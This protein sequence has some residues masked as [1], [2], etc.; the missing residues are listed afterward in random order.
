MKGFHQVPVRLCD[1]PKTAFV[2]PWGKYQYRYMPFGLRNAPSTFQRLMDRVLHNVISFSK[3][4]IDDIVVYSSFWEEHLSHLLYVLQAIQK[5]GLTLKPSKCEWAVASCSYLGFTVGNGSRRPDDCKVVAVKN[6]PIPT[7]KTSVRAFLGLTG[8]YREFILA[9][10]DH[11]CNLTAA[12][13]KSAPETV[14]W[15]P[16]LDTEFNYLKTSLCSNPCL[17]I[18]VQGD[19]FLLQTDASGTGIGAVMAVLRR[20]VEHPVAYFSR[21]L[22]AAE[23]NY[24]ATE[25][26]GLAVVAAIQHFDVYLYGNRFTVQTDHKAL[27]FLQSSRLLNGRLAR[28]ALLL[29]QFDFNIVYRSGKVN[30]NADTLSRLQPTVDYPASVNTRRGRCCAPTS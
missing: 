17:C 30:Q 23:R 5:A 7:S 18:P 21:R 27:A 3:A 22:S 12:T 24:S 2:T 25:L 28:W 14:T 6:F 15:S 1:K 19:H 16:A 13:R 29:Q 10:A 8:Y 9:Y 4:Y 11:S 26:E 20:E